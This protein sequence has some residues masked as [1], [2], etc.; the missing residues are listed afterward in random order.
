MLAFFPGHTPPIPNTRNPALVLKTLQIAKL[1]QDATSFNARSHATGVVARRVDLTLQLR[2]VDA[3]A[4]RR[5]QS[6]LGQTASQIQRSIDNLSNGSADIDLAAFASE[7]DSQYRICAKMTPDS[8]RFGQLPWG[9]YPDIYFNAGAFY[10]KAAYGI[11]FNLGMEFLGSWAP[12]INGIGFRKDYKLSRKEVNLLFRELP[13]HACT[14]IEGPSPLRSTTQA[15]RDLL[16]RVNA[17]IDVLRKMEVLM[18]WFI[19]LHEMAH[20]FLGHVEHNIDD[21]TLRAMRP[22]QR[23]QALARIKRLEFEA[24]LWAGELLYYQNIPPKVVPNATPMALIIPLRN[25][26]L[27]LHLYE[28]I[29]ADSLPHYRKHPPAVNRYRHLAQ[30]VWNR[31]RRGDVH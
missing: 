28:V 1:D 19:I 9:F 18:L 31:Q 23:N 11:L 30:I 27:L 12:A 16:K 25:L 2:L 26:F 24:D 20:I 29:C 21:E 17:Q 10:H 13:V 6:A 22:R 15:F 8:D 5:F 4:Y 14:I 3:V 7:W